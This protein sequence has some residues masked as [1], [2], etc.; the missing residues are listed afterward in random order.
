MEMKDATPH[1]TR[2]HEQNYNSKCKQH[3]YHIDPR[4]PETL[5]K[6]SKLI[7]CHTIW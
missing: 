6:L 5:C 1:T 7:F 4:G 2:W 3:A